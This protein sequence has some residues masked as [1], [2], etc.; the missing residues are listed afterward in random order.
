M[1]TDRDA[2]V[3]I[4]ALQGGSGRH[5]IGGT[6]PCRTSRRWRL[7]ESVS[8]RVWGMAWCPLCS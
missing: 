1:V 6:G 8:S 5:G 7:Q 4:S 3:L 2:L